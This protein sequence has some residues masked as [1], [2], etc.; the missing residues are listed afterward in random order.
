MK[1]N[2]IVKNKLQKIINKLVS[3]VLK[4]KIYTSLYKE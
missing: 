2:K 1:M 4:N 3:Q